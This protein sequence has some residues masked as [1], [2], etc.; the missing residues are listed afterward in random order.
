MPQTEYISITGNQEIWFTAINQELIQTAFFSE[1]RFIF[2]S[3]H[4]QLWANETKFK[5]LGEKRF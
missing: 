1:C 3:E 2:V 4:L 5:K